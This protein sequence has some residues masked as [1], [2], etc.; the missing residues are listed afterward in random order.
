[1][2]ASLRNRVFESLENALSNGYDDITT[3]DAAEVASDLAEYDSDMEGED[4]AELTAI[5]AEW[6]LTKAQ[7]AAPRKLM[8]TFEVPDVENLPSVIKAQLDAHDLSKPIPFAL[9]GR[10]AVAFVLDYFMTDYEERS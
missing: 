6:Q 4:L 8:V 7:P 3:V 2:T 9:G 1:M 5:T 10:T